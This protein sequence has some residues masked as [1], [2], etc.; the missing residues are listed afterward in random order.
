[1]IL[2]YLNYRKTCLYIYVY[3]LPKLRLMVLMKVVPFSVPTACKFLNFFITSSFTGF[4]RLSQALQRLLVLVSTASVSDQMR[5]NTLEVLRAPWILLTC[6]QARQKTTAG[7]DRFSRQTRGLTHR[8]KLR[9]IV[10][11]Y[12]SAVESF[13]NIFFVDSRLRV[14]RSFRPLRLLWH[15]YGIYGFRKLVS[16]S[17]PSARHCW[18][19]PSSEKHLSLYAQASNHLIMF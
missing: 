18:H 11:D 2:I 7:Q 8:R 12:T 17:I 5:K 1:M 19:F 3:S 9:N 14:P 4:L 10:V 13:K 15:Y 6:L 16:I